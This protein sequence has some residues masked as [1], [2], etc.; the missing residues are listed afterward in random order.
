MRANPLLSHMAKHD[1]MLT[2]VFS[3]LSDPTRR[4]ILSRLIE[5]PQSITHLAEP[6]GMALPTILA[7]VAK[8]EAGGLVRTAKKGRTR[9]CYALADPLAQAADWIS[10]HRT[11]WDARLDRLE[12]YLDQQEDTP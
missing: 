5:G 3:A 6:Y 10:A 8:L 1:V 7:H 2:Q 11:R 12:S 9:T 4:D